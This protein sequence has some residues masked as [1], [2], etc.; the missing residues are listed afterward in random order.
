MI[1][2]QSTLHTTPDLCK[3]VAFAVLFG[4]SC[5]SYTVSMQSEICIYTHFSQYRMLVGP[6]RKQQW[7]PRAKE[8][9]PCAIGSPALVWALIAGLSPQRAGFN[10]RLVRMGFVA[11]EVALGQVYLPVLLL[12]PVSIIPPLL[13][14]LSFICDQCCVKLALFNN[15]VNGHIF[16]EQS[17][18]RA[19]K[20]FWTKCIEI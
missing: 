19:H 14:T 20:T 18:S 2:I 10:H 11:Y 17:T 8:M 15:T 4:S 5:N 1:N 7:M 12:P 3:N 16:I 6:K 13:H 9:F